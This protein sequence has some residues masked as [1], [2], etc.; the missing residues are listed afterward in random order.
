MYLYQPRAGKWYLAGPMS[1]RPQFNIPQFDKVAAEL[2]TYGWDMVSPA[3]LDDPEYRATCLASD[4]TSYP[5]GGP[6]WADLLA[7]D[8]KLVADG[9]AGLILLPD[10]KYSR[11]AKLEVFVALTCNKDF[12]EYRPVATEKLYPVSRDWVRYILGE[13]LP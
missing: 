8:V 4:G 12:F 10:W 6:T 1:G 7:R 3:E 2:R 5:P 11:G 13:N 9:V